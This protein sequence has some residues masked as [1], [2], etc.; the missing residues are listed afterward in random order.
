MI[1]CF[2]GL[3]VVSAV[4]WSAS[5]AQA[6]YATTGVAVDLEQPVSTLHATLNQNR[7]IDQPEAIQL[8]SHVQ[9]RYVRQP[10]REYY[11]HPQ[12]RHH[13]PHPAVRHYAPPRCYG[14]VP[15][16]LYYPVP[17]STYYPAPAGGVGVY[18]PN[19]GVWI[20]F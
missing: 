8:A 11:R 20:G 7:S 15:R 19:V 1:R 2:V 13:L 5:S 6:S 17:R 18:G 12:Y 16:P 9:R 4:T 3:V 10:R 14:P